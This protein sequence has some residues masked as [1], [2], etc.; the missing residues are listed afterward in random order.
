MNSKKKQSGLSVLQI[1]IA[2]IEILLP[3]WWMHVRLQKAFYTLI[4]H[5][6]LY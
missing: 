5:A 4:A 3:L 2:V 1:I 6:N